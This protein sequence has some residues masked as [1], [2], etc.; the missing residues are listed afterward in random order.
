MK[1]NSLKSN[2][3]EVTLKGGTVIFFSYQ[4][5]VAGFTPDTGYFRTEE[6]H[7][8]TTSRHIN[9]WLEREGVSNVASTEV[10]L[11]SQK[12]LDELIRLVD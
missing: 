4:T 8:T 1:L 11:V 2:Q 7:S 12:A 5:P 3:T 10:E 6:F 9:N